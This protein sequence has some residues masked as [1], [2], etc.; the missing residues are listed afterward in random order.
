MSDVDDD[1]AEE[2]TRRVAFLLQG[3]MDDK[4]AEERHYNAETY[5]TIEYIREV[6]DAINDLILRFGGFRDE[7][8]T[9]LQD[10][11][12][13]Q[14]MPEHVYR[15]FIAAEARRLGVGQEGQKGEDAPR[16]KPKKKRVATTEDYVAVPN[17]E[18][19]EGQP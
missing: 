17:E 1:G 6:V 16:P 4:I 12:S 5:V 9:R 7:A 15:Q 13:K 14:S 19:V 11:E 18:D 10:V 3:Y 8:E 2:F